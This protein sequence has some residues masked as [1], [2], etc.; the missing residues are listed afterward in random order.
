MT[1]RGAGVV[2]SAGLLTVA[3]APPQ[4][5]A[6]PAF[7]HVHL[8]VADQAAA[9]GRFVRDHNC[10]EAIVPGL[11]PGVRCGASYILFD[12]DDE[13]PGG[14]PMRGWVSVSGKGDRA[15]VDVRLALPGAGAAA[16]WL[17]DDLHVS[18]S[19]A[20]SPLKLVDV[21]GRPRPPD[22]IA[23]IAYSAADPDAVIAR[24]NHTRARLGRRTETSALIAAPGGLAVE[25]V[26]A[27]NDGPDAFWCPMHPDVRSAIA[28]E[29]E[30]C[31]MTLVPIPPP[32]FGD[33]QLRTEYA[34]AS[35]TRGRLTLRISDPVNH[36]VVRTFLSVHERL[37]H[38]FLVSRD[39]TF[40]DHVHPSLA[41]DG[42]FSVELTLPGPGMYALFV[43]GYPA[44]GTPQFLQTQLVT[45]DYRGDIFVDRPRIRDE[46]D[47]S[48]VNGLAFRLAPTVWRAGQPARLSIAIADAAGRPVNDLE[49][50]LGAAGHLLVVSAD[51]TVGIHS[52]PAGAPSS[53]PTVSFDAAI[54]SPGIYKLWLQVQRGGRVHTWSRA[55]ALK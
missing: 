45:P 4:S 25:I 29:C 1:I 8:R 44:L 42:V 46:G 40:F 20:A 37:L 10:V 2:L 13:A 48:M 12:R 55:F 6:P 28:G 49:P 51:L 39:L 41:D 27:A 23:H 50:Y 30:R 11:G 52:H 21:T 16:E 17:R 9:M 53:G 31:R 24:L 32:I 5:P 22:E 19:P 3:A 18:S 26:S 43:D 34:A 38:V 33:Y 7:H 47:G 14:A 54:P 35:A 36:Q 15:R